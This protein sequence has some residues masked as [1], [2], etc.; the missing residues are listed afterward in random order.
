MPVD[1]G[2]IWGHFFYMDR[3]TLDEFI[4]TTGQQ[5]R[6]Q[7]GF[8][9]ETPRVLEINLTEMA[10]IKHGS[11]IGYY[12]NIKFVREG[13]MEHGVGKMFGRAFTGE[14]V[15]LTKAEGVGSLYLADNGKKVR[16]IQLQG[17]SLV[18]NGN[19]ILA[20]EPSIEWEIKLMRRVAAMMSGGLFNIRL[21]GH[22][23]VAIT[24][25]FEPLTLAVTPEHPVVTDPNAT[26]AWSGNLEPEFKTDI[27]FK[28][29]LGR[30]SGESLQMLF[31]GEGFVV[32][33]PMEEIHNAPS[34]R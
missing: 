33:H 19:D 26:V 13:I 2:N 23:M 18:V 5:D 21:S 31:K 25:H 16:I 30:G 3:Y 17:D 24:T 20:F 28:T 1:R 7:G 32:V 12:G 6:G 29:L 14:G 8:E 15:R 34:S 4:S 22:G 11:M 10:W 27:Q 9:L